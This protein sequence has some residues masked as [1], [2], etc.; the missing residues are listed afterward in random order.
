MLLWVPY[1]KLLPY[2]ALVLI[3][4]ECPLI[5]PSGDVLQAAA[6]I[7]NTRI[8]Y[9]KIVQYIHPQ[10][11]VNKK[12]KK[13][14]KGGRLKKVF[15]IEMRIFSLFEMEARGGLILSFVLIQLFHGEVTFVAEGTMTTP[16]GRCNLQAAV[17]AHSWNLFYL[18]LWLSI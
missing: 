17:C 4:S 18:K 6:C 1:V 12:N 16:G 10:D 7:I 3:T 13:I 8:R 2:N 15:C 9:Y 11:W 14:K 5:N